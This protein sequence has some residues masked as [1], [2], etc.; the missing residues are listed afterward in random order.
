[1]IEHLGLPY[2][3]FADP[4][5]KVFEDYGTGHVLFA[6]KQT[7]VAIDGEGILRWIWRSGERSR[8]GGVP[9]P[10]E[11]LEDVRPVLT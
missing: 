11:V 4:T 5:W 2:A 8:S 6:P 1:V 9:M 10:R 3:L 7:W